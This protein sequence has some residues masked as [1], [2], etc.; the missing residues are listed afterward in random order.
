MAAGVAAGQVG[1]AAAGGQQLLEAP[2]VAR[3]HPLHIQI[4]WHSQPQLAVKFRDMIPASDSA[5]S[6]STG[7]LPISL[8]EGLKIAAERGS[9]AARQ[10]CL[11]NST[12]AAQWGSN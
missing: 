8:V 3:L 6:A 4:A 11:A 7:L 12:T 10:S 9:R 2:R 5:W 1:D